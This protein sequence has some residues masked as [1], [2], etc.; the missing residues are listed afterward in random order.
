MPFK[1]RTTKIYCK[2]SNLVVELIKALRRMD[3]KSLIYIT[4]SII[5]ICFSTNVYANNDNYPDANDCI[6]PVYEVKLVDDLQSALAKFNKVRQSSEFLNYILNYKYDIKSSK[7]KFY[8]INIITI[9]SENI[10]S[11]PVWDDSS[12]ALFKYPEI[13][14]F[15]TANEFS[16]DYNDISIW[17]KIL[18]WIFLKPL[19]GESDTCK[20]RR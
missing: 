5:L 18:T 16:N 2:I 20:K 11:M 7:N 10:S 1:E 13:L 14:N 8:T 19:V 12:P 3:M 6:Y 4:I 9:I 17:K 15:V